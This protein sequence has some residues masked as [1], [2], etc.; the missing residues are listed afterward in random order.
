MSKAEIFE[1]LTEIFRDVFDNEDITLSET[2]TAADIDGWDSLTH[3]T[4]L[5]T[6]EDEFDVKFSMKAVQHLQNVGELAELIAEGLA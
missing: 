1:K 4:L 2:T 5:A 6:V 3:I